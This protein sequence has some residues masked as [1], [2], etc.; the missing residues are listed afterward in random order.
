MTHNKLSYISK[1]YNKNRHKYTDKNNMVHKYILW[2]ET[3]IL[4]SYDLLLSVSCPSIEVFG[5]NF[6]S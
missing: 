4:A 2:S 3:C 1:F 6:I 5:T